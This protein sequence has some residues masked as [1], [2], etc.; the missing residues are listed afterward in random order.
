M[1]DDVINEYT[2]GSRIVNEGETTDC[3]PMNSDDFEKQPCGSFAEMGIWTLKAS[4]VFCS[5]LPRPPI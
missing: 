4:V 1:R 2:D 5:R 3:R